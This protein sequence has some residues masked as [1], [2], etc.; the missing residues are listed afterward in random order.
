[1]RGDNFR[2]VVKALVA[3][4][5]DHPLDF[6]LIFGDDALFT[7]E[8]SRRFCAEIDTLEVICVLKF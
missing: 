3:L 1:V 6:A 5:A 8:L 2:D 4:K 7:A